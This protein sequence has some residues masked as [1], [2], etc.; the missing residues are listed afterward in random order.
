[1]SVGSTLTYSVTATNHG[2]NTAHAV[3]VSLPVADTLT[4][5][6]STPAGS[7]SGPPADTA[8]TIS[9]T[10]GDL[11]SGVSTSIQIATRPTVAGSLAVTLT[12][13][14]DE[15]DTNT[16]NNAAAVSIDVTLAQVVIEV[17]EIITVTDASVVLP[18]AMVTVS[19]TITVTDASNVV[20]AVMVNIDETIHVADDVPAMATTADLAITAIATPTTVDTGSTVRYTATVTN[21]GPATG[22]G[23]TISMPVT[24]GFTVNSFSFPS[25]TC[26]VPL[27]GV[28]GTIACTA[29]TPTPLGGQHT[30]TADV[31]ST[32]PGPLAITFRASGVPADPTP[33]NNEAAVTVTV[34]PATDLA[35]VVVPS[36]TL[37]SVGESLIYTVTVTNNGPLTATGVSF[38]M[39]APTNFS[40]DQINLPPLTCIFNIF[41][42]SVSCGLANIAPG[43]SMQ[44]T[45]AATASAGPT[46]TGTFHAASAESDT[47]PANNS[48]TVPVNVN[49]PP[50]VNAGPDRS[51]AVATNPGPVHLTGSAT[52]P[53]GDAIQLA[54]WLEN[55]VLLGTSL[56]LLVNLP[57]GVHTITLEVID[58]RSGVGTDTVT[59]AV[60][61]TVLNPPASAAAESTGAGQVSVSWAAV[62][63]STEYR[64]FRDADPVTVVQTG[65]GDVL[66]SNA[67]LVATV[68]GTSWIDTGLPPLVRQFYAVIAANGAIVSRP[69]PAT[70]VIVQAQPNAAI[71]GFADTHN[72]QFANLG[73]GRSVISGSAFSPA[74]EADALHWCDREHGQ[75]GVG[76]VVGH[77]LTGSLG[78]DVLGFDPS[79]TSEFTGWPRF[80]R[81]THQQVYYEWLHRAFEG[82]QR[83]LVVH[84][85]SNEVLCRLGDPDAQFSCDDM[86]N[87]DAQLMAAK[88]LEAYIDSK[89]GGPGKG[90]YRIA[91]SG[92]EARHIINSGKM[93]VILG[94][95]VDELFGC[96]LNTPCTR[97]FVRERLDH[98]YGIGVRHLF[99]VAHFDNAF[100]S[101]AIYNPLF[102]FANYTVGGSYFGVRECASEGYQYTSRAQVETAIW[103]TLQLLL[104]PFSPVPAVPDPPFAA[105]CNS[106]PLTDLGEFLVREMMARRMIIDIDHMSALSANRV[107]TIAESVDY[108]AVSSGHSSPISV[109]MG[110]RASEGAKTTAQLARIGALGGLSSTILYQGNR[111]TAGDPHGTLQHP[112]GAVLN[113]C[114][115]SSKTFAQAYMATVD[116]LGGPGTASVGLG[117]DFNGLTKQA[118]PR[119]G[120]RTCE[121][122]P[123]PGNQTNRVVYPFNI[124]APTGV[125]AGRLQ[126]AE[127]PARKINS[128][129]VEPWDYNDD[130]MAHAGMLPDFIEDL[131][132]VGVSDAYLQPLF[133]SAEAYVR[134]WER[135]EEIDTPPVVIPPEGIT[136]QASESGGARPNV[137]TELA[138]FLAGGV[139]FDNSQGPTTRLTPRIGNPL[140]DVAADTLFLLGTTAVTFRFSDAAGN[141]GTATSTVTVVPFAGGTI[142]GLGAGTEY[143]RGELAEARSSRCS[144]SSP[145]SSRRATWRQR[146]SAILRRRR[147][148]S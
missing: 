142:V 126:K 29:S 135:A 128:P 49:R 103:T 115:N 90:W 96:G 32:N 61:P 119:F 43:G 109:A 27:V 69:R 87:V 123:Q 101:A 104:N 57:F 118:V 36:R 144:F 71:F 11:A 140:A 52:D 85:L 147:P 122:D 91:Y 110:D 67:R 9:C 59:I 107:L 16:T 54:R 114:G 12:V 66:T 40:I 50:T 62:P 92:S 100:G 63:G 94:I 136:I 77:F 146:S 6:A 74:G 23:V 99:P 124:F 138:A 73:F 113:D 46:A 141:I 39:P 130:G 15:T 25:G 45:V 127:A 34:R 21:N 121:G 68:T 35:I 145:M 44:F 82:G 41:F 2:P 89:S 134:M 13:S 17:T 76:D 60:G 24:A 102:N 8:G 26:T 10:L 51:V 5:V 148:V 112:S 64:V 42:G 117:S 79:S 72:H 105:D 30:L 86:A 97:E 120:A 28:A 132:R 98:Y 18:A 7:C 133:R 83:L 81:P 58:A 95:E 143:Q 137:R 139:A 125:S 106:R 65:T 88:G 80:D 22:T 129:Q 19:E 48:V 84:A 93:A 111:A 3:R 20:P 33:A 131:R 78:H 1:M 4:F 116:A 70:V 47:A 108:P 31:T 75:G 56:D 55:G 38:S 37:L 14:S 53:D